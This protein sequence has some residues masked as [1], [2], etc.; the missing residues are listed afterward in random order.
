[1]RKGPVFV[2]KEASTKLNQ[3]NTDTRP[4]CSPW[5]DTSDMTVE[6]SV[7]RVLGH[8]YIWQRDAS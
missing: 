5:M 4:L 6:E 2:K 7:E 8:T 1:M 3:K